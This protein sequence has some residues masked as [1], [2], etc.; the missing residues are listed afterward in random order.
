MPS[1]EIEGFR[2]VL[3]VK[4]R[5]LT[6]EPECYS[7]A[8]S[9][10]TVNSSAKEE[11]WMLGLAGWPLC[12]IPTEAAPPFVLFKGWEAQTHSHVHSSQTQAHALSNIARC[13]ND[14]IATMA[15]DTCTS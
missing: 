11:V 15:A 3:P 10:A 12:L 7:K 2:S 9:V 14:Y 1:R 5:G 4:Q 6:G 8:V 13:P